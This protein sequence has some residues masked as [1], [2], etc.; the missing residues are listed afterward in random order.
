VGAEVTIQELGSLGEFIAAIATVLTLIY[1]AIQIR[2]NTRASAIDSHRSI[3]SAGSAAVIAIA[4][5]RELAEILNRGLRDLGSLD[6]VELTRLSMI[7]SKILSATQ[8][9]YLESAEARDSTYLDV[10]ASGIYFMLAPGGRQWWRK[11]KMRWQTEFASWVNT[12]L[13]L[14]SGSA[15]SRTRGPDSA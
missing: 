2:A 9:G 15:D 6:E 12:R 14:D 3:N 13:D 10:L 1:L 8:Q 5:N 4:D 11:N 7:V